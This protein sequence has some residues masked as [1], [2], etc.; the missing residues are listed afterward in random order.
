MTH[1]QYSWECL[2]LWDVKKHLVTTKGR[3][4]KE[5]FVCYVFGNDVYKQV[6]RNPNYPLPIL[7]EKW[8]ISSENDQKFMK[9]ISEHQHDF[10]YYK[11][12][13]TSLFQKI[14]FCLYTTHRTFRNC[15]KALARSSIW[16]PQIDCDIEK[17]RKLAHTK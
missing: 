14:L 16:W 1:H 8:W 5:R 6:R 11:K 17:P 4:D 10:S 15:L 12:V 13:V 3:S 2:P 7:S 9:W